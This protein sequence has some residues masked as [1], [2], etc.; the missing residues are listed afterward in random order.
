MI[1]AQYK[2]YK[3]T[4]T[5]IICLLFIC[6]ASNAQKQ[7]Y[8]APN[9]KAELSKHKIV[10][11]LPFRVTISFKK[12]PENFDEA[13]NKAQELNDGLH[14]Q[15]GMYTYLLRKEKDYTVS[16]QDI[17]RTNVLLKKAGFFDKI[18]ETLPDSL[19]KILGVDAVIKNS[20]AYEKTASEAGAIAKTILLGG[21]GSKTASGSLTMQIYNGTGGTLLWRF[22][23]EMNETVFSSA[24]EVMERMMRKVS[25]NF[26]YER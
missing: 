12:V 21:F 2:M 20:Y 25:R 4:I 18:D 13:A 6:F 22:Y 9:L 23:K 19:C 5:L 8:S 16:F 10:A 11:I 14:M 17:D 15:E 1:F 26:P 3:K 24:D 7:E